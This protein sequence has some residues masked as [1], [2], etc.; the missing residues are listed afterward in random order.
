MRSEQ[1]PCVQLGDSYSDGMP[2]CFPPPSRR[3]H[4]Y[5]LFSCPRRLLGSYEGIAQE[6]GWV[7]EGIS[8]IAEV[9]V[10][11]GPLS[12][13]CVFMKSSVRR[14]HHCLGFQ[15][16]LF[17]SFLSALPFLLL[18]CSFLFSPIL[19]RQNAVRTGFP[20]VLEVNTFATEAAVASKVPAGDWPISRTSWDSFPAP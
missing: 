11:P 6:L 15:M 2:R 16:C 5:Q 13:I 8:C 17:P 7:L 10:E 20:K 12:A 4:E 3:S 1:A 19:Q 18:F 14:P 9:A